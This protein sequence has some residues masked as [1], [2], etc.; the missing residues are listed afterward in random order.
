MQFT[1]KNQ[2]AKRKKK[3][4]VAQKRK[5]RSKDTKRALAMRS[6]WMY[7]NINEKGDFCL[8]FNKTLLPEPR[9]LKRQAARDAEREQKRQCMRDAADL[10]ERPVLSPEARRIAISYAFV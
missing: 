2:P 5:G 10:G 1:A 4:S 3:A 6:R 9:T 8:T 7:T